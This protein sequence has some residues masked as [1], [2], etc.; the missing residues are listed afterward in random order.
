MG[1]KE[2]KSDLRHS[3]YRQRI[4]NKLKSINFPII[5]F[6]IVDSLRRGSKTCRGE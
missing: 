4:K 5:Y 3:R 6:V 2:F 1:N